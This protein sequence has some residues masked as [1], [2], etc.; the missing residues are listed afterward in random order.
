LLKKGH[1][2]ILSFYGLNGSK[3]IKLTNFE[4]LTPRVKIGEHL[5]FSFSLY[6]SGL[7]PK[8]VRLEYG[9]YYLK[10]NGQLSKKVFKISERKLSI[11]V[12]MEILRKQSFKL[13][14][15]RKFYTGPHQVSII[16]NG[17]ELKIEKFELTN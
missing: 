1:P 13:I 3:E 15:T 7:Q 17:Q 14:T 11:N 6:Q 8:T 10:Q 4:V 9:I 2:E 16:V 12:K 5:A